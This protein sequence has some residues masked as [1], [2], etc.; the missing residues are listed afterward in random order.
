MDG[1]GIRAREGGLLSGMTGHLGCQN[2]LLAYGALNPH[3]LRKDVCRD[4]C[5]LQGSQ[6][7]LNFSLRPETQEW[8]RLI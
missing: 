1:E 7:L 3:P 2:V 6:G 5:S 8:P 4:S